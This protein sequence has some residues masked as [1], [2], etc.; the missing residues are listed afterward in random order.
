MN[1]Y[2]VLD[3]LL[4]QKKKYIVLFSGL[5]FSPIGQIVTELAKDFNAIV[6]NFM[7]LDFNNDLS[8]INK[9]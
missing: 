3:I 4:L 6:L 8:V 1:N 2:S 9:F 5:E 7:H